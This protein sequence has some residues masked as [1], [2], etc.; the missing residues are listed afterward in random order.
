MKDAHQVT[1]AVQI[2]AAARSAIAEAAE[3]HATSC[4]DAEAL[5]FEMTRL[6][7]LIYRNENVT[8]ARLDELI[9]LLRQV[10]AGLYPDQAMSVEQAI[11]FFCREQTPE[12]PSAESQD[13]SSGCTVH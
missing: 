12:Q 5:T 6:L 13:P 9:R 3:Q 8:P 1:A 10:Y 11:G 7:G 4:W 2:V